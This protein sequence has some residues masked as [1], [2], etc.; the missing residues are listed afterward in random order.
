M[1][2]FSRLVTVK[3]IEFSIIAKGSSGH[4]SIEK[5][6]PSHPLSGRLGLTLFSLI[7]Y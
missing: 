4:P 6:G 2:S 3:L 7:L 1:T 5:I